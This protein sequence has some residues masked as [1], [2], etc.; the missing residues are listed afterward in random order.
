LIRP[1][2]FAFDL[3]GTLLNSKKE[4]SHE[5]IHALNEMIEIGVIVVLASG[6]LGSSMAKYAK[7]F[8]NKVAMLTMNGSMV[9]MNGNGKLEQIYS[10]VLS[11]EYSNYLID[12]AKDKPY[13]L[14]FYLDEKLYAVINQDNQKWYD[15]YYDQTESPFVFLDSFDS[16]RT[17][18]PSKVLLVGDSELL[19][20]E[21]SYFK[22]L[23]SDSVY[24]C[25]TWH[26][27]LEF[28]NIG[29]NKGKGI[30]KLAQRLNIENH[31]IVAF[32]DAENDIPML[33]VAGLGIAMNNAELQVKEAAKKVSRWTND[34]SG[35]AKE[36]E[37]IKKEL[38]I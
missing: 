8:N 32:G 11:V 3:D 18:A 35:I 20:R 4:L 28:M 23:W 24:M 33:Q 7:I 12:Y 13:G 14:N 27:Y 31:E 38:G 16:L 5:N 36:W 37:L 15:L 26:H 21:Q 2:L 29:V 6:R 25:R 17:K 22:N 10:E 34:E 1:K 19:D 9:Y 30:Q